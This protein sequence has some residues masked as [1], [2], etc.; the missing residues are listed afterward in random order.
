MTNFRFKSFIPQNDI[1]VIPKIFT[2]NLYDIF[3]S[4]LEDEINKKEIENYYFW[5]KVSSTKFFCYQYTDRNIDNITKI[6]SKRIDIKY[7]EKEPNR[8]LCTRHNRNHI[9]KS[10]KIDNTNRCPILKINDEQCKYSIKIDG[11]CTKHYKI[12]NNIK[13][14]KEVHKKINRI[15]EFNKFCCNIENEINILSNVDI[16]YKNVFTQIILKDITSSKKE[17]IDDIF[18]YKIIDKEINQI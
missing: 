14:I 9:P 15:E 17:L 18:D 10:I 4:I 13:D 16:E 7:N 3:E 1:L 11:I 6:C 5:Y 2:K 8:F 12:N